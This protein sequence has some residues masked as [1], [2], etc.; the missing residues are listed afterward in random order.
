MV[1]HQTSTTPRIRRVTGQ[2]E[3]PRDLET[4]GAFV[5]TVSGFRDWVAADG[6]TDFPADRDR[7]HLYI[8]H[9]CPWAHRVVIYRRLR[10][11]E[12]AI[13]LTAV[14]PIRDQRGWRFTSEPDPV[15]G[16]EL[17]SEAYAASDP[18][19][20][21]RVTVPVLW[22]KETSRIVNNESSEIIR[23]LNFEFDDWGDPSVDFYPEPLRDEIDRVNEL[24][25]R[26]VNNGVYGCGFASTQKAY[27]QAFEQLFDTLDALE[28]RLSGARYLCGDWTTEA[29]W[30]LFPTLVRFDA[31]YVGHFK[32][33]KRRIVDYPNLWGY[34]RDLFQ[35]PGIAETV[36]FDE[37]KRHYFQTHISLNPSGVVPLGPEID[38]Q[39][40]H[41]RG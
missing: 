24:V 17:L 26:N 36:D 30:R 3:H 1:E 4:T 29:D 18:S 31:V 35:Q 10:G 13:G 28:E 38:W 11:L 37:I 14:D 40:P 6:S 39:E 33:N 2:P 15:N 12:D 21:G 20:A 19:H 34:C 23:M 9:P 16:F 5:R 7:Y 8:A 25:Y 27:N 41:G 22:D 32:C